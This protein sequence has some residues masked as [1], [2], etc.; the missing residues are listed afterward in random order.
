[1]INSLMYR[2]CY[3]R[4]GEVRTRMDKEP[5]FDSVRQAVI[6]L[7]DFKLTHFEEA[8]TSERW[9][10][11]IYKVKPLPELHSGLE[12]SAH[13]QASKPLPNIVKLKQP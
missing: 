11:R 4:F 5:G 6:G 10:V 3:Y 13:P 8:Y 1:M 2:L 7:K 9:L 12:N